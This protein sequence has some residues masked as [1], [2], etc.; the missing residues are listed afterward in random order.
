M[1][2][3]LYS[4]PAA[5]DHD[6]GAG[7]PERPD[8]LRAVAKALSSEGFAALMRREAPQGTAEAICRVHPAAYFEALE[9]A[10]PT[11]GHVRVDGDTAMNWGTWPAMLHAAG[12]ASQAVRDVMGGGADNAFVA[13]R[14]PGHHAETTT[15]MGFC[16]FNNAAI[17]AR[18]AQA[19]CGAE[20]AAI[21][22]F[23]VHHGNGTQEIFW[24][25]PSVLYASTHQMPLYPGTG[26]RQETGEHNSVVNAPLRANDGGEAFAEAMRTVILPR[27]DSFRPDLIIISAGFDAHRR[28]PLAQ[29]RLV[30]EDFAWVTG[31]LMT[32]AARHCSGR[33]VSL[34][35]G[36]YDLEGLAGS[37]SAHVETLLGA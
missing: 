2:T 10:A 36:G 25:D 17:A 19:E 16:F 35:E 31:E 3:V 5:L 15:P 9:A 22:D 27:I 37:V 24:A 28:D 8:R 12:A 7:H 13:M 11:T 33:I 18:T 34:L 21:I 1:T 29:L 26:A 14:P 30:E 20:R 32:L 6:M 4:H 23:D